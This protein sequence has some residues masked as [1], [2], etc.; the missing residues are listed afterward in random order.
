MESKEKPKITFLPYKCF[1]CG[2]SSPF[3]IVIPIDFYYDNGS[4]L[5]HYYCKK[6]YKEIQNE[7][8]SKHVEG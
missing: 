5:T 6:C 2:S 7:I 8:L 1:N 4:I 3:E